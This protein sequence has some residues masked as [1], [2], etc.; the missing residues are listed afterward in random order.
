MTVSWDAAAYE[1]VAEAQFRWALEVLDWRTWRGDERVIDAGCG[2]GRVAEELLPRL[3][4][5]HV[6]A[7]DRDEGMLAKARLRLAPYGNRASVVAADLADLPA[8]PSADVVLSTAVL[9]WVPDHDA[10]FRGFHATLRAGGEL[11]VQCGGAGNISALKATAG[12]VAKEAFA[13]A[14]AAWSAPWHFEDAAS[15]RGRLQKAGFHS[16]E[17]GL[18]DKPTPFPDR[19]SFLEFCQAAPLRPYLDRLPASQHAR[20]LGAVGDRWAEAGRSWILDYVRLNVRA[21]RPS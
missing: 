14:F 8:L 16:I 21:R 3:P 1:R 11:L 17:V 6:T 18:E 10:A 12:E 20:F 7:V 13:P 2:P 9:H 5:G 15:T 4:R 19:A